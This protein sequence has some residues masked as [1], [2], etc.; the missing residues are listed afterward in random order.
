MQHLKFFAMWAVRLFNRVL[1]PVGFRL[2]RVTSPTRSFSGLFK[3][4][5]SLNLDFETVMDVGVATGTPSIYCAYPNAEYILV[6]PVAEFE[7]T[8]KQLSRSLKVQ[9]FL[10]AAGASTGVTTL[11]VHD[12]RSGSSSL[13][14]SEGTSLDG[15]TEGG[16]F[17]A[18][19][20]S[21][22]AADE[23]PLPPQDRHA[24]N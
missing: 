24:R 3:H 20:R 4:F 10:A 11:N 2:E 14:Q 22:A 21:A 12:H 1:Y 15:A 16:P 23:A 18:F 8:L 6:E 17:G 5:K 7:P 9:Y 13:R 19:G